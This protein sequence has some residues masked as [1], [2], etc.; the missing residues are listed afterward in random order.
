MKAL[1]EFT[2]ESVNEAE[3]SPLQKEYKEYFQEVLAEFDVKS[4]AELDFEKTKEF[5]NKIKEGWVK[6]EGRKK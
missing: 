6:G 2:T 3:H 4:P 1:H 5:F